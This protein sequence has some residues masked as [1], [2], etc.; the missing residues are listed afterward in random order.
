MR[1]GGLEKAAGAERRPCLDWGL[2]A[3]CFCRG[4]SGPARRTDPDIVSGV[5]WQSAM[6]TMMAGCRLEEAACSSGQ[7]PGSHLRHRAHFRRQQG[8]PPAPQGPPPA[9]QGS[10]SARMLITSTRGPLFSTTAPR[11]STTG[12]ITTCDPITC[13]TGPNHLHHRTPSTTPQGIYPAEPQAPIN[14][15]TGLINTSNT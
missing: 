9:P 14:C 7:D 2:G 10:F 1:S 12:S 13:P 4:E 15:A 8:P 5:A 11:A 3:V 6:E